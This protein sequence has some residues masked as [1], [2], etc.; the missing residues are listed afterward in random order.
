MQ[1][2]EV[3]ANENASDEGDQAVRIEEEPIHEDMEIEDEPR[4]EEAP[5]EAV[6]SVAAQD[7]DE[8]VEKSKT[9]KD[10]FME[11]FRKAPRIKDILPDLREFMEHPDVIEW[12]RREVEHLVEL[13]IQEEKAKRK[14]EK[15]KE[16]QQQQAVVPPVISTDSLQ[17]AVGFDLAG[18]LQKI[19]PLTQPVVPTQVETGR[20]GFDTPHPNE[21][22]ADL[23]ND[24]QVPEETPIVFVRP[25]LRKTLFL[26]GARAGKRAERLKKDEKQGESNRKKKKRLLE[27]AREQAREQENRRAGGFPKRRGFIELTGM[28]ALPAGLN[29]NSPLA[30]KRYHARQLAK[31]TGISVE[32][33]MKE[34]EEQCNEFGCEDATV[35]REHDERAMELIKKRGEERWNQRYNYTPADHSK[36]IPGVDRPP[37]GLPPKKAP[38]K[39]RY[40]DEEP[41]PGVNRPPVGYREPVPGIDRPPAGDRPREPIPGVDRPPMGDRGYRRFLDDY[42]EPI[43]GVDRPPGE[44][45]RA[46]GGVKEREKKRRREEFRER[47][48]G[49][50]RG[51]RGG[52]GRGG[53]DRYDDREGGYGR[54]PK[55][56]RYDDYSRDQY[57]SYQGG[58]YDGYDDR[59]GYD[60]YYGRQEGYDSYNQYG[61]YGAQ[62][63]ESGYGYDQ[64]GA[65]AYYQQG[66]EGQEAA[67]SSYYQEDGSQ[68]YNEYYGTSDQQGAG[69]GAQQE[70]HATFGE[71]STSSSANQPPAT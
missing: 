20:A 39:S 37:A 55:A 4:E 51:G 32:E 68:Y 24:Q 36:G 49:G 33:A 71:P 12:D 52:G 56:G 54:D 31:E 23:R 17:S 3:P 8:A 64:H 50:G 2:E 15:A 35:A 6:S 63:G 47:G 59:G 7:S 30:V 11:M 10:A 38:E 27:E 22:P 65:D 25:P 18:I 9:Q 21:A 44:R 16:K 41:I 34:I 40:Q 45:R 5:T 62:E 70:Y 13:R 53:F 43:P 58:S 60:D 14:A 66:Y 42:R 1:E 19:K 48:R 61:G 28:N 29:K 69:E 67:G 57:N 26:A 46:R